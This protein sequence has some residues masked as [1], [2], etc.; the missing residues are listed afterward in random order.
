VKTPEELQAEM[1]K[2]L[3]RYTDLYQHYQT[4]LKADC[5]CSKM[6][7]GQCRRCERLRSLESQASTNGLMNYLNS[8]KKRNG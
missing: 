3:L 2:V 7:Q 1:D 6:V 4:A 8:E 5:V